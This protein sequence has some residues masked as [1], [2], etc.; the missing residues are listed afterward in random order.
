MALP[1]PYTGADDATL[2]DGCLRDDADAWAALRRRHGALVH[3]VAVAAL[4]GPRVS[5]L[6]PDAVVELVWQHL[7]AHAGAPLRA[8]T[9]ECQLRSYLATLAR[10]EARRHGERSTSPATFVAS[11]PTPSGLFLDD[12]LAVEPAARVEETLEKLPPNIGALVRLR[13]RGL[14]RDDIAA[15]LGMSPIT[16]RSNLERVAARLCELD[17]SE[18]DT[19]LIWRAVLDAADVEGRVSLALRTEDDDDFRAVRSLIE[20]TWRAVGERAL[21]RPTARGATCLDD[22]TTA[23]FVD[24][25][26]RGAG[27]ARAEGHVATCPRCIDE[28][29]ALVLDLRLAPPLRDAADLDTGVA[30][31]AACLATAR[32]AAAEQ[33]TT[34]AMARGKNGRVT[35]D[36]HRLAQAGRLL[37][38]GARKRAEQTS[39]VVATH[40]PDD[41]EAPLIAFEALVLS[42][43]HT[44]WRAIDDHVAR[45]S[46]CGRLRLLAA[47]AQDLDAAR[48]LAQTVLEQGTSDPGYGQD[49][50]A[51]VALPSGCALPREIL[52]ERL[53][54]LIPEAVRF[55]L[56]R[57]AG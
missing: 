27:R 6:D 30:V 23:A 53:R 36:L 28:A 38:G 41:D 45:Q 31:A 32:F 54:A 4:D 25:T 2:V 17:A 44:A 13:L 5:E 11:L 7:I 40:V 42:D 14:S 22:R 49:A 46:L 57:P 56:T 35:A 33:L 8:W 47:A 26:L 55:V 3:A 43:P 52:V 48:P 37:E 39:A 16:V 34:R 19:A 12:L 29:A 1:L 10:H 51:V 9:G 18:L 20:K 21:G 24:G 15:T 50:R